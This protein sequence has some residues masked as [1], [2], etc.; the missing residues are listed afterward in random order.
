MVMGASMPK[1]KLKHEPPKHP[2]GLGDMRTKDL[3][4]SIRG[5]LAE[6]ARQAGLAQPKTPPKPPKSR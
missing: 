6:K 3:L 4:K 5:D 2:P 1:K